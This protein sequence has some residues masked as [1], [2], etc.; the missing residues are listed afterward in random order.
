MKKLQ[1]RK[2]SSLLTKELATIV[3]VLGLDQKHWDELLLRINHNEMIKA[4][5]KLEFFTLIENTKQ[6]A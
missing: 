3:D 6:I 2:D 4:F 5:E 1:E